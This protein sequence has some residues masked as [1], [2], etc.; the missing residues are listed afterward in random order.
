MNV[1]IRDDE[2]LKWAWDA[3]AMLKKYKTMESVNRTDEMIA[4]VDERIGDIK[5]AIRKYYKEQESRPVRRYFDSEQAGYYRVYGETDYKS[6]EEA[7]ANH[8]P[9]TCYPDQLGRWFEISHKFF[10]KSNGKV[11]GYVWMGLNW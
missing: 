4:W 10:Q 6:V 8:V 1:T 3:I 7:E 11:C 2:N 5:I 9:V